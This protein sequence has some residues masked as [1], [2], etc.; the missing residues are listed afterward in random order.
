MLRG[1]GLLLMPPVTGA[2]SFPE[3]ACS[4]FGPIIGV[5]FG[6]VKYLDLYISILNKYGVA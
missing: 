3:H 5:V 2:S 4:S 6:Y 1:Y